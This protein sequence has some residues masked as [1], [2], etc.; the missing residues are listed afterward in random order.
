MRMTRLVRPRIIRSRTAAGFAFAIS[1][2]LA[3]TARPAL[4]QQQP[5]FGC[6]HAIS[7]RPSP[8]GNSAL[9]DGGAGGLLV[10]GSVRWGPGFH[11]AL[12]TPILKVPVLGPTE[13]FDL[14]GIHLQNVT[15]LPTPEPTQ[16]PT[17]EPFR[18]PTPTPTPAPLAGRDPS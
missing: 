6:R 13:S 1:V 2:A 15:L 9:N 11:F 8:V 5:I 3:G 10:G 7:C 12:V 17:Q 4:A 18:G 16:E 14:H